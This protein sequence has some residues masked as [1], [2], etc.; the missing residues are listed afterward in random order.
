MLEPSYRLYHVWMYCLFHQGFYPFTVHQGI[1]FIKQ[2]HI[3]LVLPCIDMVEL[4]LLRCLFL[5]GD[6]LLQTNSKS[7][8][9][10]NYHRHMSQYNG[11]QHRS[12]I[13]KRR[14]GFYHLSAS[15]I[16]YLETPHECEETIRRVP[17]FRSSTPVGQV[18]YT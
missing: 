18:S 16:N 9:P 6:I 4:R 13:Y 2:R 5:S 14:F 3:F 8:G 12:C 7:M 15:T 11:S 1:L 17:H 10:V